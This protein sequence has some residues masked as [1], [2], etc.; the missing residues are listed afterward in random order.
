MVR[1]SILVR[2]RVSI[3]DFVMKFVDKMTPCQFGSW[4]Q[5]LR[6]SLV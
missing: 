3:R 5:V 6:R 4:K 2:V 1:I